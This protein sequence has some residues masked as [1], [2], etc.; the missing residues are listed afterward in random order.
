MAA[1][2][3]FRIP[4]WKKLLQS[5]DAMQGYYLPRRE[6]RFSAMLDVLQASLPSSF[7]AIDLG[8]GP[9]SLSLRILE[10]FPDARV[11][12]VDYDPV[13]MTIGKHAL[14][15]FGRRIKLGGCRH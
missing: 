15:R 13:V 10:R 5:W 2:G 8:C 4:N 1:G 7:N 12:A 6:M 9:G 3:L 11:V 14:K